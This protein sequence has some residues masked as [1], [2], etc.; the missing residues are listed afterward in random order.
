MRWDGSDGHTLFIIGN[1][2]DLGHSAKTGY[3]DFRDYMKSK[4]SMIV[5]RVFFDRAVLSDEDKFRVQSSIVYQMVKRAAAVDWSDFEKS[6]SHMSIELALLKLDSFPDQERYLADDVYR[7]NVNDV[8]SGVIAGLKTNFENWIRG[9]KRSEGEQDVIKKIQKMATREDYFLTFNYT[10]RIERN[11]G[12]NRLGHV[13]HIHGGL[14][15]KLNIGT[16]DDDYHRS[17]SLILV[18]HGAVSE[19]SSVIGESSTCD[20]LPDFDKGIREAARKNVKGA[21]AMHKCFFCRVRKNINNHTISRIYS[22][23]FSF[24]DVDLPYLKEI[25]KADTSG[26]EW[27]FDD[28]SVEHKAVHQSLSKIKQCGFKGKFDSSLNLSN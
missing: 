26:I 15:L 13:C 1:G 28:Y 2:F 16:K 22:Y 4:Y 24:G 3:G 10:N 21:L 5:P 9:N 11:Y 25:L 23:G 20:Q 17:E 18:G 19:E 27:L 6:L 7:K 14:D 8:C 12:L